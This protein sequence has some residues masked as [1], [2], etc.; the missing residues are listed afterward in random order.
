MHYAEPPGEG[1]DDSKYD[2]MHAKQTKSHSEE[3]KR[4]LLIGRN[5]ILP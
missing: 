4:K 2:L 1:S 5:N 3:F